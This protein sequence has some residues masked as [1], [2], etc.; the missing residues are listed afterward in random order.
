MLFGPRPPVEALSAWI[1]NNWEI[2]GI[3]VSQTQA[4]RNY[5]YIFLMKML[6]MALQ[7]LAA[8]Q[9]MVHNLPLCLFKWFLGFK[10]EGGNMQNTQCG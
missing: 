3:E 4:L 2:N 9:W 8:G 5:T 6:E 10:H 7:A 1:R